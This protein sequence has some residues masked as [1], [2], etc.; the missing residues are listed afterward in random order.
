MGNPSGDNWAVPRHSWPP[1]R[2]SLSQ[3]K[4]W[5]G[6]DPCG[7]TGLRCPGWQR[8]AAQAPPHPHRPHPP[9][10]LCR[11]WGGWGGSFT[12]VQK[13]TAPASPHRALSGGT[14]PHLASGRATSCALLAPDH[15]WVCACFPVSIKNA[16]ISIRCFFSVCNTF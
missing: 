8:P 9:C 7:G 14:Y 13:P 1:V 5:C 4:A 15:C 3:Q 11:G 12:C 6:T 2:G 16:V 10:P